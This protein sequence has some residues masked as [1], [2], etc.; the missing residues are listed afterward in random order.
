[1]SR[2]CCW[3]STVSLSPPSCRNVLGGSA[4]QEM[5]PTS[6]DG[7]F[8]FTMPKEPIICKRKRVKLGV[9]FK[10]QEGEQPSVFTDTRIS[11][12]Q[13]LVNI[14]IFLPQDHPGT[15]GRLRYELKA[16]SLAF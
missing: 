15:R 16:C 13:V 4:L 7:A 5:A 14:V 3:L 9:L 10:F 11:L 6:A 8:S 12:Y 2:R 1:M